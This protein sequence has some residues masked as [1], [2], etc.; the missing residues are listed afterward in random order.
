MPLAGPVWIAITRVT[1]E[2]YYANGQ[3]EHRNQ[4]KR[5]GRQQH[6]ESGEWWPNGQRR[7]ESYRENGVGCGT[8]R[9]WDID[10]NL[11][12]LQRFDL[13]KRGFKHGVI[14]MGW[15]DGRPRVQFRFFDGSLVEQRT[16]PPWFTED[17]I[18]A[19]VD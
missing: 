15:V 18:R 11:V 16:S 19:S 10:G 3:V 9:Y 8:W 1:V 2:T 7:Q 17:E 6:G 4:F 14:P 5:W 13:T 12:G